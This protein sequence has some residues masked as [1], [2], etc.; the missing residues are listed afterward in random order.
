[1]VDL[2]I[3]I[4]DADRSALSARL[5]KA[6]R[7][8]SSIGDGRATRCIYGCHHVVDARAGDAAYGLEPGLSIGPGVAEDIP[9]HVGARYAL[10]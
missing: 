5:A 3:N 1:M 9:L 7:C 6:A 8:L 2:F 10:A 4:V